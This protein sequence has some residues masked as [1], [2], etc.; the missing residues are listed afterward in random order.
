MQAI[1]SDARLGHEPPYETAFGRLGR[2]YEVGA[3]AES[4]REA[5]AVDERFSLREPESFGDPPI[6]AVHDAA[7]LA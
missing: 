5:L 1:Y 7:M 3:R 4:I 6:I 2:A